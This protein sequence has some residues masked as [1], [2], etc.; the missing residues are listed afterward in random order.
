MCAFL[1]IHLGWRMNV[2]GRMVMICDAVGGRLCHPP[3]EGCRCRRG[4]G[5]HDAL[6]S[7]KMHKVCIHGNT[8]EAAFKAAEIC[9]A[10]AK[11]ERGKESCLHPVRETWKQQSH[12]ERTTAHI[13]LVGAPAELRGLHALRDEPLHRPRVDEDVAL[14]VPHGPLRVALRLCVQCACM[15]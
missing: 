3:R 15:V 5:G 6:T 8:G 7:D 13:L 1:G 9:E 10:E 2:E 14:L 12:K 4:S 11:K